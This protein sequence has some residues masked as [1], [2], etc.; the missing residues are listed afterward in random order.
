MMVP[1]KLEANPWLGNLTT[2]L[3]SPSSGLLVVG[4]KA[5]ARPMGYVLLWG[6]VLVPRIIIQVCNDGMMEPKHTDAGG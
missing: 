4:R 3:W 6:Y 5:P 2:G 1:N